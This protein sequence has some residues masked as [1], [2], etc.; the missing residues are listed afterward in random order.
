MAA[1]LIMVDMVTVLLAVSISSLFT[2]ALC[3]A[4]MALSPSSR[5]VLFFLGAGVNWGI[6]LCPPH[7]KWDQKTF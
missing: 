7:L 3:S 5:I 4:V 1:P 2:T 6:A